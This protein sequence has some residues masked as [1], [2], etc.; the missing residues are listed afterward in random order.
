MRNDRMKPLIKNH[1]NMQNW[2]ALMRQ[3]TAI[4]RQMTFD[5]GMCIKDI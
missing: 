4:K 2:K 1:K 5:E 3:L